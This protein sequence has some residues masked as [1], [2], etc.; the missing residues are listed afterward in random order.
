[1]KIDCDVL[2]NVCKSDLAIVLNSIKRNENARGFAN[3][4]LAVWDWITRTQLDEIGSKY[5]R[6]SHYI[7][8][9]FLSTQGVISFL[10]QSAFSIFA[11]FSMVIPLPGVVCCS[12]LE[13][14]IKTVTYTVAVPEMYLANAIRW[15]GFS[16]WYST[17]ACDKCVKLFVTRKIILNWILRRYFDRN[18]L[19]NL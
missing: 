16:F 13:R 4:L 8:T 15:S 11:R 9:L 19:I 7:Q 18:N 6:R 2:L 5:L 14:K 12:W 1:M 10:N 3:R 17:R